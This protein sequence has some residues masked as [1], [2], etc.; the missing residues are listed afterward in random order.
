[1]GTPTQTATPVPASTQA[2]FELNHTA[3][4][5]E[6]FT[7]ADGPVFDQPVGTKT[8]FPAEFAEDWGSGTVAADRLDR[9]GFRGTS[10]I[11]VLPD[12]GPITFN[13]AGNNGFRFWI[14]SLMVFDRWERLEDGQGLRRAQS[15]TLLTPGLH[16][17]LLEWYEWDEGASVSFAMNEPDVLTWCQREGEAEPPSNTVWDIQWYANRDFAT[18]T[19]SE[20]RPPTFDFSLSNATR[21]FKATAT[22]HVAEPGGQFVKFTVGNDDGAILYVDGEVAISDWGGGSYRTNNVTVPLSP[23]THELELWYWN[24]QSFFGSARISFDVEPND[25]II[26]CE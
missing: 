4:D 17:F 6:W 18:A 8:T 21:A 5:I 26:W 15:S 13:I 2:D 9:I 20:R 14:D 25:V 23:G 16:S 7:I 12:S 10:Q 11:Y 19:G 1:V 3:W 24:G 22:I